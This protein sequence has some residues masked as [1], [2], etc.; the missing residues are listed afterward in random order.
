MTTTYDTDPNTQ[1]IA[2]AWASSPLGQ[3]ER[4]VRYGFATTGPTE[5]VTASEEQ[6]TAE[7]VMIAAGLACG[8]AAAALAGVM[9][10]AYTDSAQPAVVVPGSAPQ[11]AVVVGPSTAAPKHVVSEQSTAPIA[12]TP[13]AQVWSSTAAVATPP[14]SPQGDT[15]VVVE[16]PIPAHPPLPE[17]P[18]QQDP[19]DPDPE[20]PKPPTF[21]PELSLAPVPNPDPDPT[22]KLPLVPLIPSPKLNPQ[23]EPPSVGLNPQPE[24]PKPPYFIDPVLP[25]W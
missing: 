3:P 25:K 19:Q 5:P 14:A 15:T 24:P 17:K 21:L 16:V 8:I 4:E 13:A 22:I 23:P 11:H 20:P 1:T 12:I 9:F 6:P 7:R 18:G 2:V 10:F